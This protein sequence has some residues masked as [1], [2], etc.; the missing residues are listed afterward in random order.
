ML[1][2][3]DLHVSYDGKTDVLRGLSL[4][5]EKGEWIGII[6]R[7]GS[8]KSTLLRSVHLFTRPRSGS[9][10]VDG[11]DLMRL[12]GAE[13]K[14]MRRKIAFIFQ[15]YNL[16]DSLTV[17]ENVLTS[18]LGY[19]NPV[20]SLLGIFT[21]SDYAR[22][23]KSIE[24][25]GLGEKMFEKAKN[26]SGGQKQRV[27]IAKALCQDADI[28]LADEPVSS[29][30]QGTTVQIMEYFKLIHE[31][32]HKTLLINLHNVELAK[33]YCRRIVAIDGGIVVYDG[34]SEDLSDELIERLYRS[35]SA[36]A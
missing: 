2:L 1:K 23:T 22:A 12:S 20:R 8:G 16:I 10:C 35:P 28:I 26:L 30:D 29:L 15:D 21:E 5:V 32:K 13:L 24:R 3:T 27:A 4:N 6:G 18:R 17:L 7:S 11:I 31:K 34:A 33:K 25:V 36:N 14:K 9:V 19:Q